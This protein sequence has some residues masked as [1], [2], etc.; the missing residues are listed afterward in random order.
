MIITAIW[1]ECQGIIGVDGGLAVHDKRDLEIFK[2]FTDGRTLVMGRSTVESLP[3]KLPNR[4]T[5]CMTRNRDYTNDKCDV[6]LHSKKE[7]LDWAE[8]QNLQELI[9]CG[10][11]NVYNI[12]M[13]E[14]DT[15]I[16]TTFEPELLPKNILST[17]KELTMAPL[18][19]LEKG[20]PYSLVNIE[21]N[22]K[23][24]TNLWSW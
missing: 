5:I 9:I 16:V 12:F 10:G 19:V 4:T 1:A 17:A 7:V 23:F 6:I 13:Q 24:T 2:T 11:E 22:E 8:E 21:Q 20:A 14:T 18:K 15:A 3:K